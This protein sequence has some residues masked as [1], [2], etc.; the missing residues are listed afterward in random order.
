[1]SGLITARIVW[2]RPSSRPGA[3]RPDL[4][5]QRDPAS[6]TAPYSPSTTGKIERLHKT[7][8]AEFLVEHDR[9]HASIAEL[10]AALD[11]WVGE[12]NTQRPH[13]SCGGR[14]PVERFALAERAIVAVGERLAVVAEQPVAS[15]Q[16]P[17]GVSRWVASNGRISVA[18]FSYVVGTT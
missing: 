3:V 8:R 6:A 11:G 9:R 10:Q 18:G 13:Q 17:S 2:I 16:R 14:P 1:M 7:I 4:P 12:Y 5:G 15:K